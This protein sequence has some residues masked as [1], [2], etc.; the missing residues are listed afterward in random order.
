MTD[1]LYQAFLSRKLNN[2]IYPVNKEPK[3]VTQ[4]TE[5]SQEKH[6]SH[7]TLSKNEVRVRVRC[8][9]ISII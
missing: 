1:D 2:E 7:R 5:K 8:V 4:V 3:C 6:G 9:F